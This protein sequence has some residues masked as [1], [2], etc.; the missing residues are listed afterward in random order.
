MYSLTAKL[1]LWP[2][3]TGAWH[4]LQLPKDIGAEI[5]ER[6]GANSRGF[7]SLPVEV[8]IGATAW[9]TSIFP[10][11]ASGSYILPVKAAVRRAEDIYDGEEVTF[12]I[13]VGK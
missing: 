8:T 7:G 1:T 13:T 12:S 6:F 10:V 4:F 11:K 5:K 9:K 2:T 3:D